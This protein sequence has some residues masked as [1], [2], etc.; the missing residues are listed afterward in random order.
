MARR[1][2]QQQR[3]LD[4]VC[5]LC[6]RAAESFGAADVPELMEFIG[7][8]VAGGHLAEVVRRRLKLASGRCAIA[9]RCGVS[10]CAVKEMV[11]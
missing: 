1:G 4:A 10:V 5:L 7:G 11:R 9:T 2:E 6:G 3:E 8:K